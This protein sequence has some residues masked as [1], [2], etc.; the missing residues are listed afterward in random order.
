M[1]AWCLL[2]T[3]V[4]GGGGLVREA[5]WLAITIGGGAVVFLAASAALR[6]PERIALWGM[7]PWRR[8]R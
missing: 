2:L 8:T 7:L 6:S 3:R 5:T 4:G 1:A